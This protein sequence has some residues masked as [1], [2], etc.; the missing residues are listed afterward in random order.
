VAYIEVG[1]DV[2]IFAE[3]GDEVHDLI[4]TF[5]FGVGKYLITVNTSLKCVAFCWH[6]SSVQVGDNE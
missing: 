4:D 3:R 6:G 2:L 1:C 5:Y